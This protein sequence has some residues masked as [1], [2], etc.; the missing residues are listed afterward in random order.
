MTDFPSPPGGPAS[1][2]F[3]GGDPDRL[4]EG[5]E[6]GRDQ[7][8]GDDEVESQRPE[9]HAAKKLLSESEAGQSKADA[10]AFRPAACGRR[11]LDARDLVEESAE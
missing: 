7:Q 4:P 10:S 1:G 9:V 3:R 5:P 2:P 11:P 8:D 6:H